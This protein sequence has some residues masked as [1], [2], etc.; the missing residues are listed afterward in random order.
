MDALPEEPEG[1]QG[2]GHSMTRK[3]PPGRPPAPP[4]S[5]KRQQVTIRVSPTTK[6]RLAVVRQ[7]LGQYIGTTVDEAVDLWWREIWEGKGK[8]PQDI[9]A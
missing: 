7:K 9:G 3:I 5:T 1:C 2:T 4:D 6:R 8:P